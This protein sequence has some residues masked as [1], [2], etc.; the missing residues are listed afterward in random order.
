MPFSSFFQ[1]LDKPAAIKDEAEAGHGGPNTIEHYTSIVKAVL[2]ELK[3]GDKPDE[4]TKEKVLWNKKHGS[5]ALQ[6]SIFTDDRT[7]EL[8]IQILAPLVKFPIENVQAKKETVQLLHFLLDLNLHISDAR[9]AWSEK[10]GIVLAARRR[11]LGLDKSE[12]LNM[13]KVVSVNGD[14]IDTLL[15]R[16]FKLAMW[17]SDNE[18]GF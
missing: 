12:F 13:L 15:S 2:N 6:V 9:L 14:R 11:A 3:L 4:A 7:K 1:F 5:A 18:I 16:D 10:W 8:T 17:G